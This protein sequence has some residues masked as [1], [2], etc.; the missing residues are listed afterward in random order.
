M[1]PL[2]RLALNGTAGSVDVYR[3]RCRLAL[4]R[5]ITQELPVHRELRAAKSIVA[6]RTGGRHTGLRKSNAACSKV[7]ANAVLAPSPHLGPNDTRLSTL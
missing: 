4:D 2:Q 1:H 5:D 6:L 3:L 7:T